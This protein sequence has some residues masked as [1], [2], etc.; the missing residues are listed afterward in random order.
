MVVFEVDAEI[1]LVKGNTDIRVVVNGLPF[2]ST[3]RVLINGSFESRIG[4][5]ELLHLEMMVPEDASVH[6]RF[7]HDVVVPEPLILLPLCLN[8][9]EKDQEQQKNPMF[10]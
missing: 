4:G 5:V 1:G 8:A 7:H 6:A 2:V 3:K 10:F 9:Y